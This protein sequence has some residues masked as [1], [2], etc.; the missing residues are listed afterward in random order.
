[1]TR[2]FLAFP[3]NV[4]SILEE[5]RI[6]NKPGKIVVLWLAGHAMSVILCSGKFSGTAILCECL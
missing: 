4:D 3:R 1:M 5:K 6:L 2:M